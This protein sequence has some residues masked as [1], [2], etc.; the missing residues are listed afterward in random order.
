[1]I[2]DWFKEYRSSLKAIETEELP[3]LFFYRPIA[4]LFVKTIYRTSITPNQI[5]LSAMVLGILGGCF[6]MAGGREAFLIAGILYMVFNILDCS[7]GQ[8][9][10]IKKNGTLTGRIIDGVADYIVG[11]FMYLGFL[12]GYSSTF[13]EP[14]YWWLAIIFTGASNVIH[15]MLID[16]QRLRFNHFALGE[17]LSNTI[18]TA[19][20]SEERER[21]RK[22][23]G[24]LFNRIILTIY[25]NYAS[26]QGKIARVDNSFKALE[27]VPSVSYYKVN[28]PLMRWWTILG[29]T[30]QITV[31]ALSA[32]LFIPEFYAF[33]MI[34]PMNILTISLILIQKKLDKDLIKNNAK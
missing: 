11:I 17:P 26:R 10:R 30:M 25:L 22:I 23:K 31:M 13:S 16:H 18:D 8:L 2:K 27:N 7:D 29:P 6:A 24:Q 1:M 32:I 4:F 9:A 33:W 12:I 19:K 15:S 21:L 5:T 14:V 28:R 34:I 3:D 20:F